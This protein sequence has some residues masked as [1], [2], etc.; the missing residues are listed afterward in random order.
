MTQESPP[1]LAGTTRLFAERTAAAMMAV[2]HDR[3]GFLQPSSLFFRFEYLLERPCSLVVAA[4]WIGKSFTARR[5]EQALGSPPAHEPEA[6]LVRYHYRSD[7]E[8]WIPG[9][10]PV[11]SW[12]RDWR[13]S[14]ARAAWIVD[15]LDEGERR[16]QGALCPALLHLLAAL[17]QEELQRLRLL[18]F[19]RD[20]DLRDAAPDFESGLKEIFGR[21]FFVAQ[22]LP[23]DT[24]NA[25]DLVRAE[26]W[27]RILALIESNSLQAVAGYPAA[28]QLLEQLPSAATLSIQDTWKGI[29]QQ[30]LKEHHYHFQAFRT[31]LDRRFAS[32][33]RIAAILTL[34]G[35]EE[36][37]TSGGRLQPTVSQLFPVPEPPYQA[38]THAAATEAIRSTMFQPTPEAYRFRHKNVREWMAAFG[39]AR[40]PLG[41]LSPVFTAAPTSH[42]APP[43]IRP[44]LNDLAQILVRVHEDPAVQAWVQRA[45]RSM[46]SDLFAPSLHEV[47]RLLDR[48]EQLADRGARLDWLDD[49]ESM[50]PLL[51][52]DLDEEVSRRLADGTKHPAARIM[53]GRIA[54]ALD[55]ERSLATA[56]SIVPDL[57][58]DEG[59]RSWCASALARSNRIDLLRP[60]VPFVEAAE[61]VTSEDRSIVSTLIAAF[62]TQG[63][64]TAAQA[65][66]RMPRDFDPRVIDATRTLP[67]VLKEHMNVEDAEEIVSSLD[68][69]QI[70]QLNREAEERYRDGFFTPEPLWE[71]YAAAL[72]RLASLEPA[73]PARLRRLIPFALV[74]QGHQKPLVSLV[75]AAFRASEASRR[76]LFLAA[77]EARKADPGRTYFWWWANNLLGPEDLAWLE[78]RLLPLAK[79]TPEIWLLA[80]R[81][82]EHT[83]DDA[84]KQR[85]RAAAEREAPDVNARYHALLEEQRDRDQQERERDQQRQAQAE[86][87]K[88]RI[89]EIDRQLLS[90]PD[91]GAQQR[92]WQLSWVNF[93]DD[94]SRPRNLIGSWPDVPAPLQRKVLDACLEALDA[95]APT[96]VPE[97]SS[98][99]TTIQY[100]AQ[101]LRRPHA[102]RAR[103]VRAH[104]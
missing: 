34:T 67:F 2:H 51:V 20:G 32:S 1:L 43:S 47:R 57:S 56:S 100:E 92:L 77:L 3:Y 19:A 33:A 29:L 71:A 21:G 55:L 72:E 60:L 23:L 93:S 86:A 63:L 95:V 18:I 35:H 8:S 38:A 81:L 70:E 45:L 65:F 91:L 54:A 15:A 24:E 84:M 16:A 64:W 22:L 4:P 14:D 28:L 11:P 6:Q 49:P 74:H 5:I 42:S 103:P 52:A 78:G 40:L 62:V 69:T 41:K 102:V 96:A 89:E 37:A 17:S 46:P 59:L 25:R 79:D 88:R 66:H 104:P 12:W 39:L 53:L 76:E 36:I 85:V 97:G 26:H 68:A 13:Q 101:G 90:Q 9:P 48:L 80:L 87:A 58:Q 7:L 73:D 98:Y 44:E 61:P 30:L 94:E 99:P 50:G 31:E 82:A 75:T 27:D 83:D 10:L